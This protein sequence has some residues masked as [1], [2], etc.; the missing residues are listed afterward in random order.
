M[1]SG[2]VTETVRN[3]GHQDSKKTPQFFKDCKNNVAMPLRPNL[4]I[5]V[6]WL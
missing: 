3:D 4:P 1:R 2:E 6:L 5:S